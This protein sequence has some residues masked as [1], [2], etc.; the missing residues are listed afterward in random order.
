MPHAWPGG[1][2]AACRSCRGCKR[3]SSGGGGTSLSITAL[4]VPEPGSLALMLAGVG[5]LGAVA[6]RRRA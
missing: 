4:A 6:R 2:V 1:G 3:R 5:L